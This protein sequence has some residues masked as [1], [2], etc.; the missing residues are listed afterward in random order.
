[1]SDKCKTVMALMKAAKEGK[2]PVKK[3]KAKS[4]VERAQEF[5][6]KIPDKDFARENFKMEG[7]VGKVQRPRN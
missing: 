6:D 2:V 5:F 1:M 4:I 7:Y 3:K